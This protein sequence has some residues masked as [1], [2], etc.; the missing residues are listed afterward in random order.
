MFALEPFPTDNLVADREQYTYAQVLTLFFT[1][2]TKLFLS[3]LNCTNCS[4]IESGQG[5][6]H[7]RY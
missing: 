7:A 6:N 2:G 3:L 5:R 4:E 1:N